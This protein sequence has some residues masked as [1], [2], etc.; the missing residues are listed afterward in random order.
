LEGYASNEASKA[1]TD[2]VDQFV[3]VQLTHTEAEVG[4]K[5]NRKK[6]KEATQAFLADLL[7]AKGWI[8]RSLKKGSFTGGLV[9]A[10][11]FLSLQRALD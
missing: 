10:R 9:G 7:C 5:T 8:Y 1:L 4:P 6:L 11:V 3:V 2:A